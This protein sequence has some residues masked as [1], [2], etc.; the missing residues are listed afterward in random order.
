MRERLHAATCAGLTAR[1]GPVALDPA[2]A[3]PSVTGAMTG[4]PGTSTVVATETRLLAVD[5][6]RAS[7]LSGAASAQVV[8]VRRP[9]GPRRRGVLAAACGLALLATACAPPSVCG[10]T[11]ATVD[12]VVDGDTLELSDGKK[13]RL[14]L[15]DAPETTGGKN[16]CYGQQAAQFTV[17]RVMGKTVRLTYDEASC[18]DRFGRLLA[19]VTADGVEVNRALAE[20]GLA[21]VLYVAPA[22]QSRREEF[23]TYVSQ[24]K[25]SRIGMWGQCATVPCDK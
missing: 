4:R 7:H 16:D 1:T 11:T 13:V 2:T 9:S 24:A 5:G 18:Q 23:E 6:A 22:G 3:G 20:Q 8:G 15:V 12:R 14:L 10:P 19:Y 17:D 25:T 21:C